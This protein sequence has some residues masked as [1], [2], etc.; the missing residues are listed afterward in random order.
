M[1]M[2][3]LMRCENCLNVWATRIVYDEKAGEYKEEHSSCPVCQD[4]KVKVIA[5]SV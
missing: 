4:T 5:E 1:H 3:A 2:Q